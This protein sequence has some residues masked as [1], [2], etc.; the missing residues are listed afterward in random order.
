MNINRIGDEGHLYIMQTLSSTKPLLNVLSE[1]D[2]CLP[3]TKEQ[4]NQLFWVYVATQDAGIY[5]IFQT[6][7]HIIF[8]YLWDSYCWHQSQWKVIGKVTAAPEHRLYCCPDE[9]LRSYIYP[10]LERHNYLRKSRLRV[11]PRCEEN[12]YAQQGFELK[13]N[14]SRHVT[15][16][17]MAVTFF[18]TA[19]K[20]FSQV[21]VIFKAE[22]KL[23]LFN[24]N[25]DKKLKN[26]S[27]KQSLSAH[28]EGS[29][30]TTKEAEVQPKHQ[31]S[32]Q[33]E[34]LSFCSEIQPGLKIST[35]RFHFH[36]PSSSQS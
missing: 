11:Q 27:N 7:L 20:R 2:D 14:V 6:V 8:E 28:S 15:I 3:I 22:V 36:N 19:G 16:L 5:G 9:Y 21:D 10:P 23:D 12:T 34:Q 32:G 13:A 31:L 4:I 29:M 25:D 18:C 24:L 1:V 35:S 30:P 26:E 17:R 33:N